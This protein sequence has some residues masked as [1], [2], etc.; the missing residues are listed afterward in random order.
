[1][2]DLLISG[3]TGFRLM[4]ELRER[5]PHAN[6]SDVFF[7]VAMAISLFEADRIVLL[8]ELKQAEDRLRA[9]SSDC[10]DPR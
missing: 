2:A 1:L 3:V 6:R 4:A 5:F 9:R 10:V 8:C 7:G